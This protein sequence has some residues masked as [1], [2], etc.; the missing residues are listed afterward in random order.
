MKFLITGGAGFIGSN[1]LEKL[2]EL[3][4]EVTV[5]DNFSTGRI[6]NIIKYNKNFKLIKA[7][8]SKKGSW[9]K[10][11]KN[12]DVI[13]HLAGLAD[14]VP[15]ITK[16]D[17]YYKS[18]V[19]GTYNVMQACRLNNVRKIIYTASS[20]CYG[21]PKK[22]PTKESEKI[23]CKFPYALTKRMGEEIVMHWSKVYNIQ[24]VSL[25]LFN[26]YGIKSRT[27]GSY[28]AVF[29]VFLAQKISNKP[30]TI[31]G[32]GKQTRDFTYVS[33]VVEAMIIAANSKISNEIINIGSGKTYSI[34]NLVELIGGKRIYIPKRPGEP[35]C[36][37]ADIS[38]AKK[39]LKWKPKISLE[40]GVKI[41]LKNIHYWDNAPL[42]NKNSIKKVTKDWF[43]Y[44]K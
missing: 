12:K 43:R 26:V 13:F 11:F 34:N 9:E 38:K 1:L 19:T 2:L 42:W 25:R 8:I 23:D 29:G 28:G 3:N 40:D 27:S 35:D 15:S 22:F 10:S 30:F 20:T 24:S 4:H 7:D 44:L 36:T 37:W 5:L 31:V 16:P 39:I 17:V 33:D 18:N 6:E 41:L 21:I 14:I 32:N